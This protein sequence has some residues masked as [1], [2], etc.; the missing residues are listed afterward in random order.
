MKQSL[1]SRKKIFGSAIF[2]FI[3]GV[4]LLQSPTLGLVPER[5]LAVGDGGG[6]AGCFISGTEIRLS[7]GTVKNI[8]DIKIGDQVIGQ[9][10]SVN[11]VIDTFTPR[12]GDR[13][14][15]KLNDSEAFVTGGHP[16][17][18]TD[19]AWH[20]INIAEALK[21][22]PTL[23]VVPLIVGD[24]VITESGTLLIAS[25]T[26]TTNSPDTALYNFHT[27]NTNTFIADS[28]VVHNKGGGGGGAGALGNEL[29]GGPSLNYSWGDLDL[30]DIDYT[31]M[32]CA[33]VTESGFLPY[34][35]PRTVPPAPTITSSSTCIDNAAV[36][37][38]M[39]AITPQAD[40][41]RYLIDWDNDGTADEYIPATGSVA[42]GVAQQATH[43]FGTEGVYEVRVQAESSIWS[44]E[45][46]GV[47]GEILSPWSDAITFT[48]VA[49]EPPVI[50]NFCAY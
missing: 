10:N 24:N 17:L 27:D 50:V 2:M 15:Y 32:D 22:N 4:A 42:S 16:F 35:C 37:L 44:I 47:I 39:S 29:G 33:S 13:T 12:L 20:A 34:Y 14:L 31:D 48:C 25:I 21:E 7:D 11:T 30:A 5:A 23:V 43:T 38:T 6:G 41:V 9:N 26:A 36:T 18:G 40:N 3:I 46:D 19:G 49:G 1:S 45:I 8:E 28:F